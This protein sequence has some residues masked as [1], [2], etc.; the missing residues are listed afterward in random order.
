VRQPDQGVLKVSFFGPFYGS[1]IIFDLDHDNYNYAMISGP[2]T[3]Y[4]WILSRQP[5]LAEEICNRLIEKAQQQGF[6]TDGLIFVEHD[7]PVS[8]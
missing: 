2:D 6:D 4:L 5:Y 3:S 7:Q 8:K 1:Y